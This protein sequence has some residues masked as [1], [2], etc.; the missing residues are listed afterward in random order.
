MANNH[1]ELH[2]CLS[3]GLTAKVNRPP[4]VGRLERR[5]RP[6]GQ[7]EAPGLGQ[8]RSPP[9]SAGPRKRRS[10][11]RIIAGAACYTSAGGQKGLKPFGPGPSAGIS[12]CAHEAGDGTNT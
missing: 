6:E 7:K 5:V 9:K 2:R 12:G 11:T 8:G 10:A 3:C 4:K 1:E